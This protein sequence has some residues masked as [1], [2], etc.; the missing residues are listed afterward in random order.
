MKYIK[1][2]SMLTAEEVKEL[3]L[4][5]ENERVERTFQQTI[6]KSSHRRYV[7]LQ[8][9]FAVL[10]CQAICLSVHMIMVL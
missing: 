8:M 9:M 10:A 6:Q 5:L 2:R 4:D 3:L 7:R 1:R